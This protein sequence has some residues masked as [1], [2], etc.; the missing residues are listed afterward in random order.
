MKTFDEYLEMVTMA[1]SIKFI[2]TTEDS[3]S[4]LEKAQKE[5]EAALDRGDKVYSVY[6][7]NDVVPSFFIVSKGTKF[8]KQEAWDA[9]L[10]NVGIEAKDDMLPV[11]EVEIEEIKNKEEIEDHFG[12]E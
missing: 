4:E 10:K 11:D 9:S 5:A 2:G 1:E 8:G 7:D 12:P 3:D 6:A